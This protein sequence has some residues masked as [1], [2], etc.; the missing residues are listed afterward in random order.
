MKTNLFIAALCCLCI[1]LFACSSKKVNSHP[2][3]GLE[4]SKYLGQWYEIARYD[5]SF[6]R[7]MT[8]T[9]AKYSALADGT[10]QV[11]NSGWKNGKLKISTG[12]AKLTS[13]PGLLRVSFFGPFYSDYRV[14]MLTPD[15]STA[16]VGSGSSKYLWILSRT[17]YLPQDIGEKVMEEIARRGYDSSKLIWVDQ[18]ENYHNYMN[19]NKVQ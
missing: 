11:T 4:L 15:Y 19:S 2:V 14:L 12:K 16:V 6:E 3:T 10:I 1:P 17:P 18:A 8:N 9:I 5:H 7:N 13:T